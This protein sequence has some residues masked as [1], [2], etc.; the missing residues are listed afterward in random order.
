MYLSFYFRW[1]PAAVD[2]QDFTAIYI[3]WHTHVVYFSAYSFEE[4]DNKQILKMIVNIL[5]KIVGV[6]S[7]A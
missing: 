5:L 3:M 2:M 6:F 7:Q 4:V 1:G